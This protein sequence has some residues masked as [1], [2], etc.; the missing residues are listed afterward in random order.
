M[1]ERVGSLSRSRFEQLVA[2]LIT[3]ADDFLK[4]VSRPRGA[5]GFVVLPRRWKVELTLG[6]IMKSRRNVRNY[7]RLPQH[8]EAHLTWALTTL[9]TRRLTRNGPARPSSQ[10][11]REG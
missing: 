5:K 2:Q 9:M 10:V 1:P 4:T 11:V 6:W 3:W 7:E 8:S